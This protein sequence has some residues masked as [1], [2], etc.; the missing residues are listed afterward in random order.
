[1]AE[2]LHAMRMHLEQPTEET[3]SV[4]RKL[5][6]GIAAVQTDSV[7]RVWGREIRTILSGD[8]LM[9]ENA[10]QCLLHP[11]AASELAYRA[12]RNYTEKYNPSYGTGLIPESVPMMEDIIHFWT[13]LR[14]AES[15]D[16]SHLPVD[17][18]ERAPM[19][20]RR[21]GSARKARETQII[22]MVK[23]VATGSFEDKY[24]KIADW[25][26][27]GW[28][29]IGHTEGSRSFIRV[30]DEGGMVWEGKPRYSNVDE[31]LEDAERGIQSWLGENG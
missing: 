13:S 6:S 8:L 2:A 17:M 25:V 12:A 4:L 7:H 16:S 20:K 19:A 23:V 24:P 30:L 18:T 27:D 10:L 1:M 28:I 29:E 9:I 3:L 5:L 26:Q 31:A 11:H 14:L 15:E 21:L 22:R